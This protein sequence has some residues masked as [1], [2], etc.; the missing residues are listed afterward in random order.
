ME[1]KKVDF[2]LSIPDSITIDVDRIQF[3]QV[4]INLVKN[5]IHAIEHI[6]QERI[7][8]YCKQTDNRLQIIVHDSGNLID[9]TILSKIFLPFYTTR[10]NCAGIGLTLSKTIIEAHKGY[11][12]YKQINGKKEFVISFPITKSNND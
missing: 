7:E 2:L 9:E 10:K 12:F 1:G 8:V 5:A 11:L 3:E 4:V 6:D